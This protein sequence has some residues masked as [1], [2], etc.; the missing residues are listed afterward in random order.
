M[1]IKI[2]H[3]A[4]PTLNLTPMIDIVFLLI[5]FFMV[6]TKFAEMERQIK[7]EIPAVKKFSG[8][9]S[10][11][12]KRVVHVYRDGS[13]VMDQESLSLDE[14]IAK[15]RRAFAEHEELSVLIR[16]DAEASLQQVSQV[17]AACRDAGFDRLG[18]AVR[19]EPVRR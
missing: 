11:P 6:G 18:I 16:G 14:L 19:P 1:P 4:E 10:A 8:L 13:I 17:L 2:N 3:Q 5:I 7:L 12:A 9:A 15:L